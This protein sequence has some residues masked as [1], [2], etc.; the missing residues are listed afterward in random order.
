MEQKQKPEA[1][2]KVR[3]VIV[4]KPAPKNSRFHGVIT[5]SQLSNYFNYTSE[6]SQNKYKDENNIENNPVKT[7]DIKDYF[8]YTSRPSETNKEY[9]TMTSDGKVKTKEEKI[10]FMQTVAKD[11][12]KEGSIMWEFIF[13]PKDRATSDKY[14][15]HDQDSYSSVISK[16]MPG[17][18]K[19]I[20]FD[21]NNV[22]W[23]EDYHER[24]RTS[25]EDHPHIH[26]CF[27]ELNQ[28][29]TR[30]KLKQK[31][32][33]LFKRLMANEML[34]REDKS[35]YKE[36]FNNINMN[37][38]KILEYS[39]NYE[40]KNIDSVKE[41]YR[42]LPS[43]GR[44]QYNSSNMIPYRKAIDKVVDELLRSDDC[45]EAWN[46]FQKCLDHYEELSNRIN[47]GNLSLRKETET[48]K[49]KVQIANHIL[50]E[51]K[52]YIEENSFEKMTRDSSGNFFNRRTIQTNMDNRG[53]N[54]IKIK[55]FINGAIA[56]RQ[57]EIED[58]IEE[59][60]RNLQKGYE[61]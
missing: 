50:S 22:R 18:L 27:Y 28:E 53:H 10:A 11:L 46:N 6:K 57:R 58:E 4:G 47:G 61:Y 38:A 16:I 31:D 2:N 52:N 51:R 43:S 5:S 34:K 8:T 20:G 54:P 29:R 24:N 48:K 45:K 59:F 41:L 25:I 3:Y 12:D 15:L 9:Y 19:Q 26:L 30:G 55:R 33:N 1:I 40:L 21:P 39:K 44:L 49:L 17:F 23:W 35:R 14:G 37:K 60:L 42:V 36:I 56:Q 13:S 32:L 7:M